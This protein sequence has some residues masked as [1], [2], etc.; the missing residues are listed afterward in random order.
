MSLTRRSLPILFAPI[1]LRGQAT[2]SEQELSRFH[3]WSYGEGAKLLRDQA[4]LAQMLAAY[5]QKLIQDGM[6]P[7]DADDLLAR[8]QIRLRRGPGPTDAAQTRQNFNRMYSAIEGQEG[9]MTTK[10]NAFLSEVIGN[11]RPG[12]ALDLGM[13]LGRNTIFLAQR[14][15]DV[16]GIDLSDVAIAA[17]RERA[18]QLGVQ[19]KAIVADVNQFELVT[20]QW[21]LVCVLY[22]VIDE[23]MPNLHQRIAK[24]V[25]PGGLVIVEGVGHG[26]GLDN[27]L[28]AW[29]KWE[30]TGLQLLRLEYGGGTSDWGGGLATRLLL[31]KSA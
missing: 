6:K 20:D 11:L 18:R 25:K 17:A 27:L 10:P 16:T 4:P 22:F 8:L 15:W 19:I 30:P 24:A 2:V 9:S 3:D 1:L 13:G 7:A 31:Q 21:D 5:K 23:T 28:S 26:G 29:S 12:K 14:G